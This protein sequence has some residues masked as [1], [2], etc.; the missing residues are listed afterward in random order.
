MSDDVANRGPTYRVPRSGMDPASKRLALIA[1]GLGGSL[2]VV[3]GVWST[4]GHHSGVVPVITAPAGPMRVKP[5]NPGG[6]KVANDMILSGGLGDGAADTLAPAPETPDPQAL[7][8]PPAPKPVPAAVLAPPPAPAAAATAAPPSVAKPIAA[9]AAKP[10]PATR[11]VLVQLAALPS[12][13]AAEAEWRALT[14]RD[15]GLLS[16]RT[17]SFAE[18]TVN[19]R[20]WWRVRTGGFADEAQARA[21]CDKLRAAGGGCSVVRG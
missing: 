18:G 2:L 19:G 16:G 5:E 13:E 4:L 14:R 10:A 15:A 11:G 7:K 12:R 6:L 1:A 3:L 21:F 20:T 17:P 9:P 8:A